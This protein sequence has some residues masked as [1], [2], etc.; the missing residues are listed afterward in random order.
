MGLQGMYNKVNRVSAF[1]CHDSIQVP[2]TAVCCAL[3]TTN[4][5][6]PALYD[7]CMLQVASDIEEEMAE[8]DSAAKSDEEEI[9]HKVRSCMKC[10]TYSFSLRVQCFRFLQGN[11]IYMPLKCL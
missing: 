2:S 3:K 7:A 9:Q 4:C 1:C 11:K 10:H 6:L 5:S 8:M